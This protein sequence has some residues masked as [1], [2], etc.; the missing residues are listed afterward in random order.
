MISQMELIAAICE[1]LTC[2]GVESLVPRQTNAIIRAANAIIAECERA[3]VQASPGMGLGAWLASDDVGLSSKY[4]AGV[5]SGQFAAEYAH[6]AD[7]SDFGRCMRLLEAVPELRDKLDL[8]RDKSPEWAELVANW[9]RIES[10]VQAKEYRRA[11]KL[12]M[13]SVQRPN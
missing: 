6:P 3:P 1:E 4:M 13:D 5:L 2:Q 10:M 11:S 8:M 9:E 12:V 7:S